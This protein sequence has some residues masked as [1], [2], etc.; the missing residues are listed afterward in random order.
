MTCAATEWIYCDFPT[1][2]SLQY[3]CKETGMAMTAN[4]TNSEQQTEN[5][6]LL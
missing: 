5:G 6:T 3:N 1:L 4:E 2:E